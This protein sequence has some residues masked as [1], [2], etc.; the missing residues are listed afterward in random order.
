MKSHIPK[1]IFSLLLSLLFSSVASGIYPQRLVSGIPSITEMLFALDLGERVVGVTTNCNYPPAALKKEKIGGFALNLEKIV[2]L[3]P[4]LVFMLEDAQKPDI[5]KLKNF[6]L[7]VY[8]INPHNLEEVLESLL[9]I[10]KVTGKEKKARALGAKMKIKIASLQPETGGLSG[11]L[12]RPRVLVIVG[13][14]PLI[15][16]GGGTYIDDIVK[17]AGGQNIAG[18]ARVA[19]PQYSFEKL[20]NEDPDFLVISGGALKQEEIGRDDR[21]QRLRAVRNNRI[22]FINSDIISRPG[23]RVVEAIEALA[24]KFSE[25]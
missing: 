2:S 4:D 10:G 9:K 14:N 17:Q 11:V 23:P 20:L 16:V 5:A 7:A 13:A 18:Q 1:F 6:G 21:W 22:L 19:Y 3:K 12:K 25:L 15:V 24:Q 8:T